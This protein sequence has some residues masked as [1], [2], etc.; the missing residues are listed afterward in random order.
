MSDDSHVETWWLDHERQMATS[1][2]ATYGV[3]RARE[4]FLRYPF[5]LSVEELN[6]LGYP[7]MLR[8]ETPEGPNECEH[9]W[10]AGLNENE[11]A[12][13]WDALHTILKAHEAHGSSYY[14][15]TPMQRERKAMIVAFQQWHLHAHRVNVSHFEISRAINK[16]RRSRIAIDRWLKDDPKSKPE[17]DT[18]IRTFLTTERRQIKK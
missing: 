14:V 16:K 12:G 18:L 2:V 3:P 11:L 6:A 5:T 15:E 13:L 8:H 4:M 10:K 7:R 1:L 9:E 17:E